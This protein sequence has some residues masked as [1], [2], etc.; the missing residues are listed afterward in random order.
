MCVCVH[1]CV[2]I[3]VSLWTVTCQAPLSMGCS[4]KEYWGGLP[5]PPPG[6]LSNPGIE[7]ASPELTGRFFST[8]PPGKPHILPYCCCSVPQLYPALCDPMNY[9]TPSFSILHCLWEFAQTHVHWVGDAIQQ[10][11]SLSSPSPP[12]FNFSQHHALFQWAALHIRW[13]KYWSFSISS[14]NE[15][16]GF[17]WFPSELTGLI[18]DFQ[19]PFPPLQFESINSSMLSLLY[20]PA[21]TSVHDYWRNLACKEKLSPA[22]RKFYLQS[23][24]FTF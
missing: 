7:P 22:W 23:D 4:K 17:S 11:H 2:Q 3:F 9:S 10:S 20:G 13:P 24:V 14:L 16:S 5:F 12:A 8:E 6:C 1:S 15:Y 18:R 21:L 19:E